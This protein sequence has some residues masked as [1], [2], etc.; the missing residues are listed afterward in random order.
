[1]GPWYKED[2]LSMNLSG[3][4]LWSIASG[5]GIEGK[6]KGLFAAILMIKLLKNMQ[7]RMY[8]NN[9]GCLWPLAVGLIPQ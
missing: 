9:L 3:V 1:M 6:Q 8:Y 4:P 7:M 2:D 5:R